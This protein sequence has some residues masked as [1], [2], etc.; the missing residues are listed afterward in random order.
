[1]FSFWLEKIPCNKDI[2][3]PGEVYQSDNF[4]FS[5]GFLNNFWEYVTISE[6]LSVFTPIT[7]HPK[8]SEKHRYQ[9]L[10]ESKLQETFPVYLSP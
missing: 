4:G 6:L 10:A 7:F 9:I 2:S 5:S 3:S 8:A 1:M